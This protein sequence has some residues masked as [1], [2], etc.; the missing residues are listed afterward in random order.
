MHQHSGREVSAMLKH[1]RV[2]D[3]ELY[4]L[5]EAELTRQENNIEMI[6]S[7]STAPLDVMELNGSVFTNKT[8]E[9]YPGGRY[10]AGSEIADQVERLACERAVALFGAEHA[11]VQ[12]YSGSTANYSVFASILDVGDKVL[13][14]DLDQGG[15]L[16]HGSPANW[17]SK[18]YNH[19]F[20]GCNKE[21]E[22]I[23]YDAMEEIA[24]RE[25]PKLIICG[26]SS[27]PRL[28]DYER[29]GRIAADVGAYSMCDMAHVA[30]LVAA[31]VIPSPIP[32]MDFVSSSTTKTFC[33]AR[34]GMVFCKEKYAKILDRGTFPGCLGSIQLNTMAS[35]CWSFK[36]AATPE[37]R[38]TMVQV[39]RNAQ[40]LAKSM[41]EHG[42]RVVSGGT[43]NHLIVVDLRN[44][45]VNGKQ[46][47]IALD[48]AG[49]TVNKQM[50]PYDPQKP[51]ITS[52]LRIGTTSITQ[53]G[54]KEKEIDIIVDIIDKVTQ[55]PE[56]EA[57]IAACRK[58][59]LELISK[60]PLYP[61]GSFDD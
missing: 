11:N 9:G 21:T 24:H 40:H 57:N 60:F 32:Y 47:Q 7:E 51:W 46:M 42:F 36:K 50:I 61:A 8:L 5:V 20:Y 26:A 58:Q 19:V 56:D 34:S 23:D 14:M 41:Q 22:T 54:L 31:K 15:H 48:K 45:G 53:R 3:P 12:S 17:V 27:Y 35:K 2:S 37:F 25:K 39:V 29:V 43:D 59:A 49:I 38:E 52:G 18:M 30:G 28:I 1:T 13:A 33:S 6:A 44:K 4:S 55:A 16:T 10:Q